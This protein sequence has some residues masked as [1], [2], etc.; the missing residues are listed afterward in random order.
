LIHTAVYY[1]LS[2]TIPWFFK[3]AVYYGVFHYR[4]IDVSLLKCLAIAGIPIIL[5]ALPI[6]IPFIPM[7]IIIIGLATYLCARYAEI[8]LF[9]DALL[10]AGSIEIVTHLINRYILY[11]LL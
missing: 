8:P 1:L 10:T 3:T 7:P 6:L 9:P 2:T 5:S 4:K 11:P